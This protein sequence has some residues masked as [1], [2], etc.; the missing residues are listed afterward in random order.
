MRTEARQ[1]SQLSPGA[2][3]HFWVRAL[4]ASKSGMHTSTHTYTQEHVQPLVH[5]P[6]LT[7]A[8]HPLLHTAA[9]LGVFHRCS[10]P[11]CHRLAGWRR[12][13]FCSDRVGRR[14][15]LRASQ[16]T[17]G[18]ALPGPVVACVVTTA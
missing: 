4:C 17:P 2:R 7:G 12:R 16:V 6:H 5:C 10:P 8:A 15:E 3:A 14:R 11:G 1:G 13:P 18:A 9:A